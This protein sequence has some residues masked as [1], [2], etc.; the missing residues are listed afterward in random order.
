MS[1]GKLEGPHVP[2]PARS[3]GPDVSRGAGA[4]GWVYELHRRPSPGSG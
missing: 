1:P 4:G 2:G 3:P